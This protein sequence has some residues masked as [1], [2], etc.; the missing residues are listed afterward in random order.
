MLHAALLIEQGNP[1][2]AFH[3]RCTYWSTLLKYKVIWPNSTFQWNQISFY[4]PSDP[5]LAAMVKKED[6]VVVPSL[7][8]L[9]HST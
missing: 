8:A 6:A 2:G 9:S 1:A 4:P 3:S 5:T 7:E